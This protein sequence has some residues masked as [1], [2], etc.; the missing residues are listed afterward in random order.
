M[1]NYLYILFALF[2][3]NLTLSQTTVTENFDSDTNG[4]EYD[5][6]SESTPSGFWNGS[7]DDSSGYGWEIQ[8]GETPSNNTGPQ[9]AYN[10]SYYAFCETSGGGSDET[11]ILESDTY[12]AT[13][14]TMSFYYHMHGET[15]GT[16]YVDESTNG[17]TS[18][19]NLLSISGEQ[20]ENK[21][22]S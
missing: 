13:S 4:K 20:Q 15:I 22:D 7:D 21:T 17:G 18:W 10:G 8:D 19:N 5:L 16:L 9:G 12:S 14:T 1:K 2:A 3:F 6:S 11:F